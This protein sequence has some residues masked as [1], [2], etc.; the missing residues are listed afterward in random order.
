[1]TLSPHGQRSLISTDSKVDAPKY[2]ENGGPGKRRPGPRLSSELR[3]YYC[4]CCVSAARATIPSS[5]PL[6]SISSRFSGFFDRRKITRI[7]VW[8]SQFRA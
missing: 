7:R 5:L 1:V 6:L 3:D 2:Y 4:P 8:R